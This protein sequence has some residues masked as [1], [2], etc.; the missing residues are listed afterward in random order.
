M[1]EFGMLAFEF[2]KSMLEFGRSMLEFG[3]SSILLDL[4]HF[5]CLGHIVRL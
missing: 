3:R 1:L 2:E 5:L 4:D